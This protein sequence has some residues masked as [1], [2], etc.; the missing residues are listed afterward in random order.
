[1]NEIHLIDL[2]DEHLI[3]E[4]FM[5]EYKLSHFETLYDGNGNNIGVKDT[6]TRFTS[7]VHMYNYIKSE[8][9]FIIYE[10]TKF[11]VNEK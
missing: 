6:I 5:N 9:G 11:E 4:K 7:F 10:K 1:M 8:H 3:L 2:Q